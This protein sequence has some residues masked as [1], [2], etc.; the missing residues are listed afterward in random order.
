MQDIVTYD[1]YVDDDDVDAVCADALTNFN[2]M[3]LRDITKFFTCW[4]SSD[5]IQDVVPS[6]WIDNAQSVAFWKNF[7]AFAWSRWKYDLCSTRLP[8]V[9]R[10][11]NNKSDSY[12][13]NN[14]YDKNISF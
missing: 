8:L 1:N 5:N 3:F 6:M 11:V 4:W 9:L 7:K 10:E 14:I 12:G 2:F 13:S